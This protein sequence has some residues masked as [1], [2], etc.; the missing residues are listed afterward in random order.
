MLSIVGGKIMVEHVTTM[1]DFEEKTKEGKFL[2]DFYATWCGPCSMLAPIIEEIAEEH[3]ELKVI[4][5][6]VD[7][8]PEIAQKFGIASIPTL[9]YFENGKALDMKVGYLPKPSIEQ[10]CR[11]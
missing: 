11:L 8:A 1:K 6:D 4:K 2:V 3:S 7:V 10:F 5:I 9:I